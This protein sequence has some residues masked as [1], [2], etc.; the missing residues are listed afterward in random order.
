MS[1]RAHHHEGEQVNLTARLASSIRTSGASQG[2][3]TGAAVTP[4]L[5]ATSSGTGAPSSA[6]IRTRLAVAITA[7]ALAFL[8]AFS[9]TPA[10]ATT[11]HSFGGSFGGPGTGNGQFSPNAPFGVGVGVAS[12]VFVSD[13]TPDGASTRIETFNATGT[14][15]STFPVEGV[16]EPRS[17]AVDSSAG[18]GVYLSAL[19]NGGEPS[20]LKYSPSGLLEYTLDTSGSETSI[21]FFGAFALDPSNGTVYA[22]AGNVNTGAQ[23]IDSFDQK[24]GAFIASFDGSSGSFDGGFICPSGLAVDTTHHV[25]VLD[26][27]KGRVDKYSSAGVYEATVDDDSRGAPQAIA[28]NPQT[29]E[30]YV[31]EAGPLGLQITNFSAGGASVVDTFSAA[32]GGV[33][34]AALAMAVG[35]DG[36][37]YVTDGV[38][39]VID[40]FTTFV[41]PTVTT[42][43][44]GEVQ[45]TSAAL[46]GTIDPGGIA[47][48]DHYEYGLGTNYGSSTE[49]L[50]AGAG[51]GAAEVP[52]TIKG[53]V[54][55]TTY[56]YRIVGTNAAGSIV[57]EDQTFTTEAAPPTVDGS[58]VFATTITPTGARVHATVDPQHSPTTFRIEYGT[59]T[60]YGS[61]APEGGAEVGEQ[62]ADTPIAATLTGLEP[63]TLYHFRVSAENGVEGPQTG[64]DA[65]FVTA[66]AAP[67]SGSEVTTKKATLTGTTAPS[68]RRPRR[69]RPSLTRSPSRPVPQRCKAQPTPTAWRAATT[70]K[71]QPSKAPTRRTPP[72]SPCLPPQA[73]NP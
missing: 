42:A 2:D 21:G 33:S 58:P 48:E 20:V 7:M 71:S 59:T 12:E 25:Y 13:A 39:S 18:G 67:A 29:G 37:V 47:S 44:A 34:F 9:A 31:A 65:A 16:N 54:P 8:V 6:L 55:N 3:A 15:Q 70:S 11:G 50:D 43:P 62:S 69:P 41:G 72:S 30:V 68:R 73:P 27:C 14:F 19:R 60:A 61:T 63:G 24:T 66:P 4:S 28:T 46:K 23:E 22:T 10:L 51:S 1:F 38:N 45:R 57:G 35:P 26:A 40:R 17:V 32:N 64:T 52:A 36:T 53:L 5:P 56:H 49:E